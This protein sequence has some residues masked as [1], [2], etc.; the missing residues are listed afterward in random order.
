M[1]GRQV[2]R[3]PQVYRHG[4]DACKL[5]S[6]LTSQVKMFGS[7]QTG[8][9]PENREDPG[10]ESLESDSSLFGED[11]L[12]TGGTTDTEELSRFYELILMRFLCP[13]PGSGSLTTP[14]RAGVWMVRKG[15]FSLP[16][17]RA[18]GPLLP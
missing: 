12:A 3:P 18:E 11:G 15:V 5:Q 9:D 8:Q 17:I 1:K 4:R 16:V 14:V 10:R 6:L 7:G 13:R 2:S